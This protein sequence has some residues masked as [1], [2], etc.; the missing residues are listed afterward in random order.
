MAKGTASTYLSR[1]PSGSGSNSTFTISFW[2][3]RSQ[4][5]SPSQIL[6][7]GGTDGGSQSNVIY[8]DT[9]ERLACYQGTGG[10]QWYTTNLKYYDT[11]AWYHIVNTFDSTATGTDKIK[12]WVNG[13]L[14]TNYNVDNRSSFTNCQDINQNVL[15]RWGSGAT[16]NYFMGYMAQI[17][18]ADGT[19]YAATDFGSVDATTGVW[20]P[21]SDGELRSGITFGTNGYLLPFSNASYL[22]YDYQSSDRSGT[23]ND[24]TVSGNGYKTIDNPSNGMM[25]FNRNWNSAG[26]WGSSFGGD[27]GEQGMLNFANTGSGY[28]NSAHAASLGTYST[29]TMPFYYETYLEGQDI[30]LGIMSSRPT[31]GVS[32]SYN[33]A[34]A[35]GVYPYSGSSNWI[36]A[37]SW[38]AQTVFTGTGYYMVAVDP[39]NNKMWVGKD[40]T[41]DGDPA[42]GTG[43]RFTLAA[44]TEWTPWC[45]NSTSSSSNVANFNFGEGYF[46][47]TSAGATNADDAGQGVF[48]YDCPAG[49]YTFNLKNL[50][51][52]G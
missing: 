4:L 17:C 13:N 24:F 36:T 40:G 39:V 37:G 1:T 15:N 28:P 18:M 20:K 51:T 19:A 26:Y 16:A 7:T 38:T 3:K 8:F 44:D 32:H 2:I 5:G 33:D 35:Y 52:Y 41:W 43:E 22:G 46:G 9:S 10:N 21:K 12:L 47:S 30:S 27:T 6:L 14:V 23:T 34:T 48:K 29:K 31:G 11:T 50:K 42:A 45:H 25:T 49:F